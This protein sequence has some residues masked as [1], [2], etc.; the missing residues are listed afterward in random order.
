MYKLLFKRIPREFKHNIIKYITLFL[1]IVLS[2]FLVASFTESYDSIRYSTKKN[3]EQMNVEDGQFTVFIPLDDEQKKQILDKGVSVEE[4]YYYDYGTA[5]GGI[6][7][8]F[9]IRNEI[10]KIEILDGNLPE[11]D[12][13]IVIDKVYARRNG[14]SVGDKILIGK[15]YMTICGIGMVPDYNIPYKNL[16]DN[17]S[18]SP[19][20]GICFVDGDA[21]DKLKES[22]DI[23]EVNNYAFRL[24]GKMS[25]DELKEM[26]SEMT[27]DYSKVNDVFYRQAVSEATKTQQELKDTIGL[28]Y[29]KSGEL[30]DGL[31]KLSEGSTTL[32]D[33]FAELIEQ[34]GKL[35]AA[36]EQ[37]MDGLGQFSE[38]LEGVADVTGHIKDEVSKASSGLEELKSNFDILVEKLDEF[39]DINS[40]IK[41][42]INNY[43]ENLFSYISRIMTAVTGNNVQA[44][45][46]NYKEIFDDCRS[47]LTSSYIDAI[48][49]YIESTDTIC[50]M[51]EGYLEQISIISGPVKELS[52]GIDQYYNS[53]KEL[54][55][56]INDY[57]NKIVLLTD[58]FKSVIA[59]SKQI[60]DA[61][62]VLVE[63][64]KTLSSYYGELGTGIS[65]AKDGAD[66]LKQ[67]L[68]QL[69][70][71]ISE[72]LEKG[73]NDA[74]NN[75]TMFL[76]SSSNGRIMGAYARATTL[77]GI[78]WALGL[79]S[80]IMC[81]YVLSIFVIQQLNQ[82]I[83][84]IGA[85]YAL[86]VSKRQLLMHYITLPFIVALVGGLL[87]LGASLLPLNTAQGYEMMAKSYML[88]DYFAVVEPYLIMYCVGAPVIAVV[89]INALVV[90]KYLSR[91]VLSLLNNEVKNGRNRQLKFAG[92]LGF[93]RLF[94]IRQMIR[95]SKI[96][97]TIIFGIVNCTIIVMMGLSLHYLCVNLYKDT[98]DD[99]NY[100]N[101]Y[102]LKYPT[103]EVPEGGE[104]HYFKVLNYAVLGKSV[105]VN[106]IGTGKDSV[107]YDANVEKG[108]N[109]IVAGTAFA[110]KYF[111]HKGSRIVL[112]DTSSSQDYV[113]YISDICD[114]DIGL[115]LFMD[116]DSMR[117]L[118]NQP[119]G[120]YNMVLSDKELPYEE[121][122][123]YSVIKR[124]DVVKGAGGIKDQISA[125]VNMSVIIGSVIMLLVT[126]ILMSVI[127]ERLQ[128]GISLIKVFG[129]SDREVN[130]LYMRGNL[131]VVIIGALIAIPL[132]K[133]ITKIL[134]VYTLVSLNIGVD[135]AFPWYMYPIMFGWILISY[136]IANAMLKWK[137]SKVELTSVLKGRG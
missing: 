102:V 113:F 64:Q 130:R 51:L 3:A 120:Y 112:T 65:Q 92:K 80:L 26:L 41:N 17:L 116:E 39:D 55:G 91:S 127:I 52:T 70:S 28:L 88:P 44:G 83:K 119:E 25:Y 121:A 49:N 38:G 89:F 58:N 7:R 46:D 106:L 53:S 100:S 76:A 50:T 123:L 27:F 126:Y 48:E 4:E 33:K 125:L 22:A 94:Q 66:G 85:L 105:S 109:K 12:S 118:F 68:G 23:T 95:E 79:I 57:Y 122:R 73:K 128:Y 62:K 69:D 35:D 1:V 8:I 18:V 9:K 16:T 63:S 67:A 47:D 34:S 10:N 108:V 37:L 36:L 42:Y 32:N 2:M 74:L 78:I 14:Y 13:H 56:N 5:D 60:S 137:L 134:V 45:P 135:I 84:N 87:G 133:L 30:Y 124:Q 104:S 117:Q 97:R 93:V 21:Y 115:S 81:G 24:N 15:N 99:I 40:D 75:L 71:K 98:S 111:L 107:Y 82:D 59:A 136:F 96:C 31:A 20:F 86:G 90:N 19:T 6:F 54:S 110:K 29:E 43:R 132:G 77:R 101:M 11:D 131:F 72:E 114:Y 61:Y 129:F 103:K